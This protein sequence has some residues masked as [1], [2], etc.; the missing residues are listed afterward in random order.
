ML[1][2]LLKGPESCV[3][4][5]CLVVCPQPVSHTKISPKDNG[6]KKTS[7]EWVVY[8]TFMEV[9]EYVSG[10]PVERANEKQYKEC[11]NRD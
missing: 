10:R 4:P 3:V 1:I 9:Q 5:Q 8:E 2:G 11:Y 7:T 6:S